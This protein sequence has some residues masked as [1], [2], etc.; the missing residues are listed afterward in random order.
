[1]SWPVKIGIVGSGAIGLYYGARLHHAGHET[2][3]LMRSDY[4]TAR[5][6]GIKVTAS[7]GCFDIEHAQAHCDPASIG[8]C[9][10]V[11]VCI[12]TTGN[13]DLARLLAP[14]VGPE[15]LLLSLQNGLGNDRLL[16]ELYPKGKL[17]GG[18]CFVCIN[19]VGP[20]AAINYMLGSVAI[21]TVA[22]DMDAAAERIAACF[23]E[24]GVKTA[25][26]P[27][28]RYTQWRK[29]VWNVPFNGLA[30]AAG[31]ITTDKIV[32]DPELEQE[33]RGLMMEIQAAAAA[34]GMAIKDEFIDSQIEQTRAM[35]AYKPS[36]LIDFLAG[37]S[38]EVE[39]I[40]GEPLRQGKAA[41]VDMPRLEKLYAQLKAICKAS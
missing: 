14:L 20:A 40:W 17:L 22:A 27:D 28:L 38:V 19:R 35:D 15:T 16:Q 5:E 2:H 29:L 12:K 6:R 9:D 30:I 26:T 41:G 3:F 25:V 18:L 32:G 11:L 39:S 1:M 24:A 33:A 21:G 36:S 13:R 34:L 23:R 10:L 8:I 7:D 31:G 37:R 4:Q